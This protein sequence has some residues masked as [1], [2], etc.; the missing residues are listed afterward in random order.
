MRHTSRAIII[1]DKKILLLTGHNAGYYWTPGGGIDEG[2]TAVEALHREIKEELGAEITSFSYY[3]S[4]K[5]N[6]QHVTAYLVEIEDNF[7]PDNEITDF[8]WYAKNDKVQ[9]STRLRYLLL[10]QLVKDGLL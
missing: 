8:I 10:P 4:S 2:E 1:R 5:L 7:S 9:V 6:N 3:L